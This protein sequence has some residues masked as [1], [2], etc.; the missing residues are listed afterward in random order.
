[1]FKN[2]NT[3]IDLAKPKNHLLGFKANF[4]VVEKRRNFTSVSLLR[5]FPRKRFQYRGDVY[6]A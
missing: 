2:G 4:C 3:V 1:M 5:E 6:K